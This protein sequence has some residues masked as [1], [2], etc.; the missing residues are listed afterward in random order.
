MEFGA[1][2]SI[3]Y[4]MGGLAREYEGDV[5]PM[6]VPWLDASDRSRMPVDPRLW[7]R[8]ADRVDATRRAWR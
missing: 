3:T 6:I 4:V 8:G 2:L 1:D 5:A 7:S